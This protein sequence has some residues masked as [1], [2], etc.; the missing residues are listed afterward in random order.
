MLV[1]KIEGS[2]LPLVLGVAAE[3][4]E[5]FVPVSGAQGFGIFPYFAELGAFSSNVL[6]L[7]KNYS[8]ALQRAGC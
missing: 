4:S 1:L 3:V 7:K 6:S 2:G 5:G 8:A